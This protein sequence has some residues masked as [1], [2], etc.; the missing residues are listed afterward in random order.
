MKKKIK[1]E[2][3]TRRNILALAKSLGCD[4]EVRKIFERYD[5]LLKNCTNEVERKQISVMG[6]AE[7]HRF[8]DCRGA[9]V[10]DGQE[11]LPADPNFK[12]EDNNS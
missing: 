4:I 11:I 10:V 12:P 5:K 7:L 9:L 3:E 2:A 1:S 6:A 8:L